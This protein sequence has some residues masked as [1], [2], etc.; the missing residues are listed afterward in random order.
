MLGSLL[1]IRVHKNQLIELRTY[2]D[3]RGW[4]AVE[5]SDRGI[6]RSEGLKAS[7]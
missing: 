2:T 5:Y 6:K 1:T 7:S 4:S 3:N